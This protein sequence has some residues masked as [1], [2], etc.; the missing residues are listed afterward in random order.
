MDINNN[1]KLQT[2][3]GMDQST[4]EKTI[5]LTRYYLES[6]LDLLSLTIVTNGRPTCNVYKVY[7]ILVI[8]IYVFLITMSLFILT[9][10]NKSYSIH[11]EKDIIKFRC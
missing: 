2:H 11:I 7:M 4:C 8:R 10:P 3:H 5:V 6:T 1:N 9:S